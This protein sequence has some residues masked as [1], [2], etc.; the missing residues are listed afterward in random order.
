MAST[1]QPKTIQQLVIAVF[2]CMTFT[3][4]HFLMKR[5]DIYLA[6]DARTVGRFYTS[7]TVCFPVHSALLRNKFTISLESESLQINTSLHIKIYVSRHSAVITGGKYQPLKG[8][9]Q[10]NCQKQ[11][12]LSAVA[13]ITK[14]SRNWEEL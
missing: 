13:Y 1:T 2:T 5:A 11:Q 6:S 9:L 3:A 7:R 14:A 8:V 4:S 10:S 12:S